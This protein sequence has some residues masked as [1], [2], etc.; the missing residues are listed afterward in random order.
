MKVWLHLSRPSLT[1]PK[2]VARNSQD[3][4]AMA[5]RLLA[6]PRVLKKWKQQTRELCDN[7]GLWWVSSWVKR[8]SAT[9]RLSG[10]A[11]PQ[12]FTCLCAPGLCA[13]YVSFAV[14]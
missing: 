5:T 2:A 6:S 10:S 11:S 7:S 8:F 9:L 4:E 13:D 12:I 14:S 3:W 1:F